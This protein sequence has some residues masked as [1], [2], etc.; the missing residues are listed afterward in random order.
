MADPI[1]VLVV[2]DSALMR[3]LVSRIVESTPGLTV[4]DRAMNGVFALQKIP[5]CNPDVIVLDIEM[6]QMNG[7]EFLKER[8]KLGIDIPVVIL[9]SVAK[10]GAQITME[11]LALGAADFITKP[12]GS[13]SSD[14][15][16][17]AGDLARLLVAYGSQYRK[18]KGKEPPH[19][20]FEAPEQLFD[21]PL[22]DARPRPAAPTREKPVRRRD[23]GP[24]ELI[25]IGI[26][27][28]GPNALRDV[29]SNIDPG[30]AQPVVVVQH[31]PAGFTEEF[32]S[33]LDRICPLDVKEAAEGDILRPGRVLIAPG[34]WHITVEKRALAGVVHLS[35][36][37]TENGHRPSADVLFR[38]VASEYGNRSMAVIMT[39]MG[40]DGA[41][42]MGTIFR[43]GGITLG[44]D[45]ASSVVYGM[46]K[47][48]FEL[49]HVMEQVPLS[50]MARRISELAAE[51]R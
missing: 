2:D 45:E 51:R 1:S 5:R 40:K 39:G 9:S 23:A 13:V 21:V 14:I 27:T 6:P 31:M 11:A 12:S 32:A 10:R 20:N 17:V 41:R 48:A 7:I 50:L 3:N 36:D 28:G 18:V 43:E 47:V 30:L 46:P 19:Y 44:Q 26:S 8:K 25:A 38:S 16:T 37:P 4:A 22:P 34:D 15:H 24:T 35:Q 49:G 42:E 33:S 29:F